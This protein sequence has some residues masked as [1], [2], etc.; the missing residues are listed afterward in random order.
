MKVV[1]QSG[2]KGTRLRPYT[3]V[4][5][6]PLMPV[7]SKPV[8]ELLL[9]WLRRNGVRQVYITTGYLGHLIRS[10]CGDG[11]QWDLRIEYTEEREPL[12]TIGPLSLLREKLDGTFLVLNGDV[13]TDLNLNAFTASHR[14]HGAA[15]T[16]A[17]VQKNIRMDFGVIEQKNN[18][19]V[20]FREKPNLSHLV[21]MGI[22]CMEPE[23]LDHIPTGVPFGFDDLMFQMLEMELP[24]STFLHSGFW[25]DIGRV[26]DF[27]RA[28]ELGWDDEAPAFE[29]ASSTF[30]T[31]E[32]A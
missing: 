4:L 17:T 28:Q 9:K 14:Q 2:G 10:F 15:L 32:V 30:E 26:E 7:G 3:T 5:P 22:Y 12:G 6:K 18:K 16:I 20:R 29:T 25:L 21:S 11:R 13:L 23:M 31:P 1:I 19:V 8:L 27:Q 24:V